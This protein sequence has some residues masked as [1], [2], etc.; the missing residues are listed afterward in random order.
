MKRKFKYII[1]LTIATLTIAS[2]SDDFLETEPSEFISAEQVSE[3]AELDP[4]VREANVTGIYSLMFTVASGGTDAHDDFG[5]K[6]YDIYSDMLSSDMVLGGTTYG[7]YSSVA[8]FQSTTDYTVLDNYK[9]WRY[10]Y[11]V[12]FA[13]NSIIEK[14]DGI[15]EEE[16][17]KQILGQALAMR[18]YGYFYLSQFF[19]EEYN[20]TDMILPIYTNTESLAEP[21]SSTQEVYDLMISDLTQAIELLENFTR[22]GKQAVNKS[23]AQGLL[24]Y[25]YGAMGNYQEVFDLTQ[26]VITTGGFSILSSNQVTYN[27]DNTAGS[28]FNSVESPSWMW[29]IDLTE[30]Q[31]LD[32][33]SWW[34]QVDLFTYSYAWAGDPKLMDSSLYAQIPDND[35]R[36][37]QFDGALR[38]TN[39]FFAS[40]R[41]IGGQR[42]ITSD[43]VYMRIEEMYLLHAEAAANLGNDA[44]AI[45]ALR[46]ILSKRLPDT[47]YLNGLSGQSLLDEIYLQ[48]R[49]ELWGE[50]KSYLAMK[51]FKATTTRGDNHLFDAEQSYP[52][53]ADELTFEIPLSE[54]QNNPFIT[55]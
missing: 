36:K 10:Y 21:L 3:V 19:A 13:A 7:W 46:E 29:G 9:P 5:Q 2:C 34:G 32:L 50:G 42:V 52:Y 38:P 28:G 51:R 45:E 24:A 47:D 35:I 6:G 8:R 40:G 15:P 27:P 55:E 23:V 25:V 43:Y 12:I 11:R 53:N 14:Y 26:E 18:A 1:G 41:V 20:P 33:I 30:K 31:G 48:T 49:I 37:N 16:S 44:A 4:S 22:T 39:K 54:I 17:E